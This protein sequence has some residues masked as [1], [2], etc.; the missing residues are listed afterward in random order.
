MH[1]SAGGIAVSVHRRHRGWR[2]YGRPTQASLSR[3][4]PHLEAAGAE[5]ELHITPVSL[6]V[7]LYRSG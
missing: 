1:T 4:V 7:V 2:E 5:V 6:W 3:L